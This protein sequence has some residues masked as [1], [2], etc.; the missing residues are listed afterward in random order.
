MY[1]QLILRPL[2]LKEHFRVLSCWLHVDN[3]SNLGWERIEQCVL[4]REWAN[5]SRVDIV[6]NSIFYNY[7][8]ISKME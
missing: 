8:N 5:I 4:L 3:R 6:E 7:S 2:K 1:F